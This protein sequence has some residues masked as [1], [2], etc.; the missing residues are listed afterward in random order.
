MFKYMPVQ[1]A[2]DKCKIKAC[3]NAANRI[4]GVL[5]RVWLIPNNAQIPIGARRKNNPFNYK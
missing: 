5:R 2:A 4:F 3:T 1:Q